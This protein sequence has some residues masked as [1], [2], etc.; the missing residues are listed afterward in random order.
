[1]S[2]T[3]R[4]PSIHEQ[5]NLYRDCDYIKIDGS[6]CWVRLP[7]TP[8]KKEI[9]LSYRDGKSRFSTHWYMNQISRKRRNNDKHQLA[10]LYRAED[11]EDFCFDDSKHEIKR[12][13]IWW[14]IY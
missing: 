3:Y 1:M 2:R 13:G 14:E 6:W 10:K 8:T 4:K 7:K 11:Y 5:E 12:K 9:A